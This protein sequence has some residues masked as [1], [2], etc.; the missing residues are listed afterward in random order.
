MT[1]CTI[2]VDIGLFWSRGAL[3]TADGRL[4]A[5]S[6]RPHEKITPHERSQS[7]HREEDWW[8][9]FRFIIADLL[10]RAG[11]KPGE[12]RALAVSGPGE[13]LVPVDAAGEIIT[14]AVFHAD[15]ERAADEARE[16]N[17]QP[18]AGREPN[19]VTPLSAGAR[20]LWLKRH[21]PELFDRI[22]AALTPASYLTG[23]LTGAPALDY[24]SAAYFAPS[25]DHNALSWRG[26][27][28]MAH[29]LP[30]LRWS[31]EIAGAVTKEAAEETGLKAGTPVAAG[32]TGDAAAALGAGISAPGD[33]SLTYGWTLRL[34]MLTQERQRGGAFMSAPWLF[35]GSHVV[36]AG[37]LA[38]GALGR[39]FCDQFVREVPRDL[40]FN[41]I[42]AEA[43]QTAPGAD[44]LMFMPY[45]ADDPVGGRDP[46]A[47]GAWFGLR[48][49]HRRGHLYRAL[50]EGAAMAARRRISALS[51]AGAGPE[52]V[53]A[54]GGG[55]RNRVFLRAVA[56]MTGLEQNLMTTTAGAS[57]GAAF[58]A[59]LATGGAAPEDIS[60]WNP[61]RDTIP[62]PGAPGI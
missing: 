46:A 32:M 14:G 11:V 52:R 29:L 12:V 53:F 45:F 49:S 19:P 33:M 3:V 13:C 30:P 48:Y 26:D 41:A 8:H 42:A 59:R 51:R 43:A 47:T 17:D 5:T 20:L 24:H 21:A 44:G 56:E 36:I 60:R 54:I 37:G 34:A 1:G 15:D 18:G 39:W 62:R 9:D 23:K 10:T 55:V 6:S 31:S 27:G 2:G 58:L 7:R 57:Y 16:L 50:L 38:G 22:A 35:P 4:L 61:V 28:G 40:G 25:F